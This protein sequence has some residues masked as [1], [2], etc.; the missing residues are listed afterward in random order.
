MV[1]ELG[2]LPRGRLLRTITLMA[3]PPIVA[4]ISQTLMGFV[5][6]VMVGRLGTRE[7]AAVGVAT[8]LFSAVAMTVKAIDV[9]VQTFTAQ[10]VGEGRDGEVGGVLATALSTVIAVGAVATAAG[11]LWPEPL[12]H[13]VSG[14]PAVRSLGAEYLRF[15]YAG[16]LPFLTFFMF[17][18]VFDG[19]GRTWIGMLVGVGMNLLNVLLNAVLIFGLWG[20]PAMGVAGAALASTLSSVV[21]AAVMVAV[22][23]RADV[24]RRFRLLARGNL[25]P[26][27]VRPFLRVAW[28]PAAQSLG[29]VLGFLLFFAIL[30]R[31]STLAVAAGNA[32]MRITSIS[33]MPGFGVAVAVQTLVG[34]SLGRGDLRG[35]VRAAWGGVGLSVLYMGVFGVVFLLIPG[36]ILRLTFADLDLVRAATPVLRLMGF[37]QLVDAVGITLAGALRGAGATRTV[38][39]VDIAC[40]FC[41]MP[42]L[43]WLFGVVLAGG[44]VGAF[45]AVLTWFSL[46]AVGMT[47]WFLRGDWKA[48]RV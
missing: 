37:V 21:A 8:L 32:V 46:Y 5:D 17:R 38:M 31:I 7:L 11:M 35:A 18:G 24:R 30:G 10:R 25:Q 33:F 1:P 12:M 43:A 15:R 45:A 27:L 29:A 16:L 42:P 26:R 44:L 13:P 20:A 48:L 2:I 6:M 36:A 4:N 39:L 9:A 34:Q 14:D 28:P 23:L 19:I 22:G 40:G 41:L 3:M 47:Y